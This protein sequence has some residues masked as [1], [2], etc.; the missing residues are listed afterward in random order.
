MTIA[1]IGRQLNNEQE[2]NIFH[3]QLKL[4]VQHD[5][6]FCLSVMVLNYFEYFQPVL[7]L[8]SVSDYDT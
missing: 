1:P 5:C 8:F 7:C 4:H 3:S 6:T 2:V